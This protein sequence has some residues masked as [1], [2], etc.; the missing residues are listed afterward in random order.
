MYVGYL[1][2]ADYLLL[3]GLI[4]CKAEIVRYGAVEKVCFLSYN[5]NL[6]PKEGKLDITHVCIAYADAAVVH[7]I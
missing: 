2:G 4:P 5:A 1:A 7:I 3:G 6:A